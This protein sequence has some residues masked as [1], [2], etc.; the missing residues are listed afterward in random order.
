MPAAGP[1]SIVRIGRRS[2][3]AH[4]HHAAVGAHD[5]QRRRNARVVD[6][7][8]RHAR[9]AQH[10][11]Q[12][13]GVERRGARARAQAVHRRDVVAAGRGEAA[14]ARAGHE[15]VLAL[16]AGRPRTLRWRPALRCRRRVR[17]R[18]THR[19]SLRRIEVGRRR[20]AMPAASGIGAKR[21]AARANGEPKRTIA[22]PRHVAF[23]Q[24]VGRLRRRVRDERHRRRIDGVLAQQPLEPGDDARGD[25]VGMIVGRRHLDRRRHLARRRIDRHDVGERAADV[26]ADANARRRRGPRA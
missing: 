15:R 12:D 2:T 8:A 13:R 9:G 24:R 17:A 19:P 14:C 21:I 22:D 4:V 1:E 11:R 16:A 6:R 23:E 26:D 20:S 18:T 7:P 5:H 10:A 3:S 25:A